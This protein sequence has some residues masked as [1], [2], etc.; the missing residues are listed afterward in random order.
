MTI[1]RFE[2][3]LYLV[4]AILLGFLIGSVFVKGQNKKFEFLY[5]N[6][7][8]VECVNSL[9]FGDKDTPEGM[10]LRLVYCSDQIYQ[11]SILND[12]EL[13]RLVYQS[14][15]ISDIVLLWM[16]VVL[17]LS[18]VVLA[19]IQLLASFQLSKS[20]LAGD[21]ALGDQTQTFSVERG[22]LVFQSSVTGLFILLFSF[23][24]FY[25]YIIFVYSIHQAD[26][27]VERD[28]VKSIVKSTYGEV[29]SII[30]ELDK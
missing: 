6:G 8:L 16:V 1:K 23:A 24:F 11:Q 12:F 27:A 30:Q 4:G 2:F 29:G 18:G 28:S 3:I 22:K 9:N 20:G 17:T 15:G 10:K 25:V 19:A 21:L 26:Y 7:D 5:R 14:Q 13:R